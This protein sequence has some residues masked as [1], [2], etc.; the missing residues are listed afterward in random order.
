MEETGSQVDD[1]ARV[2]T[3]SRRICMDMQEAHE[4]V[5]KGSERERRDGIADMPANE[6]THITGVTGKL[7]KDIARLS[8]PPTEESRLGQ[9][10]D[11]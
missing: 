9:E 11:E 6:G 10:M 7:G 4:H 1:A 2:H 8:V 3:V 5:G